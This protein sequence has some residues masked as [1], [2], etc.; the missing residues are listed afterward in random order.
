MYHAMHS[1]DLRRLKFYFCLETR[2]GSKHR[3]R[4][5]SAYAT[6]LFPL[7]TL[8]L[9]KRRDAVHNILSRGCAVQNF[10]IQ[11]FFLYDFTSSVCTY[12]TKTKSCEHDAT[13]VDSLIS[14]WRENIGE[15]LISFMTCCFTFADICEIRLLIVSLDKDT[16]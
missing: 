11:K 7:Q 3:R 1:S 16:C 13:S 15:A 9:K 10:A 14:N 2:F 6:K 4:A 12:R 8:R 5:I